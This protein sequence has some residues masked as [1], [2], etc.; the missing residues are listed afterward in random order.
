M[1]LFSFG[2]FFNA[3]MLAPAGP[4]S[5]VGLKA[6]N[7]PFLTAATGRLLPDVTPPNNAF[8]EASLEGTAMRGARK[9]L[10]HGQDSEVQMPFSSR[11]EPSPMQFD[12]P[13]ILSKT[14]RNDDDDDN[15]LQDDNRGVASVQLHR[16][17]KSD[18]RALDATEEASASLQWG[19]EAKER[20]LATVETTP[21]SQPLSTYT[22]NP[23]KTLFLCPA[24]TPISVSPLQDK[25]LAD[26]VSMDADGDLTFLLPA[27]AAKFL[28]SAS[29]P[30]DWPAG[31]SSKGM[32]RLSCRLLDARPVALDEI[33]SQRE[34]PL[35]AM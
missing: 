4:A 28:P 30:K 14:R 20:L 16:V 32:V 22:S 19:G 35:L 13:D 6:N 2:L 15:I 27:S 25:H 26:S 34:R 11:F 18:E 7:N 24:L 10:Q 5:M 8:L 21:S 29:L 17:N 1:I 12:E 9:I 23:N 31:Q 33:T 3:R